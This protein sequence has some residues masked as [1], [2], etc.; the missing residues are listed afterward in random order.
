[1]I[2]EKYEKYIKVTISTSEKSE[3]KALAKSLG[4][5]FQG[6]VGNLIKR[7][8]REA[9]KASEEGSKYGEN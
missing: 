6:W 1:M 3:A 9:K 5:T 7:E 2:S 8:L 4:M